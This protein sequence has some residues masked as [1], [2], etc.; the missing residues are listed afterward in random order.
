MDNIIP[1]EEKLLQKLP[2]D[3]LAE[4]LM[5]LAVRNRLDLLLSRN[6]AEAVVASL[7]PQDFYVFLSELGAE[8]SGPLLSLCKSEQFNHIVDIEGWHGDALAPGKVL[9]W[10]A[11]L[12]AADEGRFLSWLYEADFE[13]LVLLFKNWLSEVRAAGEEDFQEESD[14][15]PLHTIDNQYYFSVRYPDF[16]EVIRFILIFLFENHR[17]FYQA[18]LHDVRFALIAEVEDLAY[19]FHRGRLEDNAIPDFLEAGSIY[20]GLQRQALAKGKKV[21][22]LFEESGEKTPTFA[23]ALLPAEGLLAAAIAGID[24]AGAREM[25]QQELVALANKVL[26]ADDLDAA[27]PDSLRLAADKAIAYVN[28]GLE[29]ICGADAGQ[30]VEVLGRHYL[31]ELFRLAFTAVD[32]RLKPLKELV[33]NGWLARWPE[34]LNILDA[35]WLEEISLFLPRTPMMLRAGKNGAT[36]EDNF[37]FHADLASI[38]RLLEMLQGLEAVFDAMVEGSTRDWSAFAAGLWGKA[39]CSN[40]AEVTIARLL[41]TAAAQSSWQGKWSCNPLPVKAW[42]EIFGRIDA[43]GLRREIARRSQTKLP[44]KTAVQLD[45]YL[46]PVFDRYEEEMASRAAGVP[47]DPRLEM[48]FLFTGDSLQTKSVSP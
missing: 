9:T 44:E 23:L 3:E 43:E 24:D 27:G 1:I 28:L 40:L 19:Q 26:V 33:N 12:L 39:Q 13:L 45:R 17:Q 6:D 41:F 4:R 16:E 20:R 37:R 47:S 7:P 5:G 34:G 8:S 46:A 22:P 48:F 30:A 25:L 2:A 31:E 15:L 21:R 29:E 42:P 10:C 11:R 18:L 32:K 35:P 36:K 38:E 14:S